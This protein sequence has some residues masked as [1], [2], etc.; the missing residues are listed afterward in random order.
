[1][2]FYLRRIYKEKGKLLLVLTPTLSLNTNKQCV[3]DKRID[4][5][6][7][8]GSNLSVSLWVNSLL[9]DDRPIVTE[10]IY[11]YLR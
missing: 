2:L 4:Q 11:D 3:M 6:M 1:M 9:V 5:I 8:A 7:M 10:A